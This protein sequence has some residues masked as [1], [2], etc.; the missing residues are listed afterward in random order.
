MD[1][2]RR[3]LS[4]GSYTL[5][6]SCECVSAAVPKIS[7]SASL[8]RLEERNEVALLDAAPVVHALGAEP[9]L[10]GADRERGGRGREPRIVL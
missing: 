9:R 8:G 1:S 6:G 7:G 2:S 10:D 4:L 5:A 3:Y